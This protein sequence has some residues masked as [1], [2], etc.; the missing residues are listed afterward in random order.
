MSFER[1]T[2]ILDVLNT[3]LRFRTY[4]Q[5]VLWYPVPKLG[6]SIATN[7]AH[8]FLGQ[9]CLGNDEFCAHSHL[10]LN[11]LVSVDPEAGSCIPGGNDDE[12]LRW[13]ARC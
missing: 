2:D 5:N 4:F 11:Y 10:F 13:S 7:P 3:L 1:A 8:L 6:R 12:K 9:V